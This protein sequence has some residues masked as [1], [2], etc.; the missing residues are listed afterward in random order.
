M[1]D[2]DKAIPFTLKW[3]G[4]YVNNEKDNGGE[5]YAGITRKDNPRWT[6]WAIIDEYKKKGKIK[7]GKKFPELNDKVAPYYRINYWNKIWGD[8]IKDQSAAGFLLDWF[9]NSGYH[10]VKAVQK[11]VDVTPDSIIGTGT[12]SAINNYRGN[13]TEELRKARIAF[14]RNIVAQRPSQ[15]EFLDGWLNRINDYK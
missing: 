11:I 9:V 15:V 7:D 5:T 12:I 13:L 10:A 8:K 6:G 1:A 14:V 4:G 2:F 3:E